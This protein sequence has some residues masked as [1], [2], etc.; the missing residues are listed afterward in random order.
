MRKWDLVHQCLVIRT[1]RNYRDVRKYKTSIK[2]HHY[3]GNED[4]TSMQVC[5]NEV[6]LIL[7]CNAPVLCSGPEGD[8]RFS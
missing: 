2:V 3:Q 1:D 6:F 5:K 7:K 8:L 4:I